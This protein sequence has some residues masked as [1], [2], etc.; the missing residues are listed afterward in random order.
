MNPVPK[1][2]WIFAVESA[3]EH[4]CAGFASRRLALLLESRGISDA[5][6]DGFLHPSLARDIVDP[7]AAFPEMERAASLIWDA[8][9]KGEGIV[10]FGDY[11]ADGVCGNAILIRALRNL[12]AREP[13]FFIPDRKSEGYGLTA[14]SLERCRRANPHASLWIT[15]DCGITSI[16]EVAQLKAEGIKVVVSDHHEPGARLPEPD[17]LINP[18]VACNDERAGELCGA[19]VAFKLVQAL[20]EL[21][22]KRRVYSGGRIGGVLLPLAALATVADSVPL[23]GENRLIVSSALAKWESLAPEGLKALAKGLNCSSSAIDAR[24]LGF[25]FAP[26]INA[27]GRI[28][29][30]EI[31]LELLLV[32]DGG[33]AQRL[34]QELIELNEKRKECE[35]RI[36]AEA[37]ALAGLDGGGAIADKGAF[38]ISAPVSYDVDKG[39]HPGVMGIVASR[40]CEETGKPV[41]VATLE[42][43]KSAGEVRTHG[44]VRV[45]EGYDAIQALRDSAEAL[46]VF[47]GHTG[48]AGFSIKPGMHGRFEELFCAACARQAT[49]KAISGRSQLHIDGT[50]ELREISFA[51]NDEIAKL[52]PFG[53]GNPEPHWVVEDVE[54]LD[55]HIIGKDARSLAV[56]FGKDGT[57]LTAIWFGAAGNIEYLRGVKR[58][59]IAFS[60]GV[61]SYQGLPEIK[62]ILCDLKPL[63][64][65]EA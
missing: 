54:L 31:A 18:H 39:W 13:A 5:E 44:S 17:A 2:D 7:F 32:D 48:A 33:E 49:E 12:G 41:A 15:V 50:L 30:A 37:R 35:H 1:Y 34:A 38:V 45:P 14:A 6:Q 22:K 8:I 23:L 51:L 62:L 56:A 36:S 3:K 55:L 57:R 61:D 43:G 40:I 19:G 60:M 28:A 10:V 64:V 21:G 58:A 47:G 16:E 65:E 59:S 9:S 24:D 26:C 4:R 42:E 11:D 25:A 46:E 53:I 27:A 29:S 52:A 20:V 63:E